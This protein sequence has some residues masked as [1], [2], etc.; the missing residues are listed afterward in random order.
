MCMCM[1][2]AHFIYYLYLSLIIHS[3][4]QPHS[5]V[6]LRMVISLLSISC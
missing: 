6:L 1:Y 3:M 4:E 5:T 2:L